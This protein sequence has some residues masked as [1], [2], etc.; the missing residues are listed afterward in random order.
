MV[1]KNLHSKSAG[2]VYIYT[3]H[4]RREASGSESLR[5]LCYKNRLASV[6]SAVG[7]DVGVAA[8]SATSKKPS[9]INIW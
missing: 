5:L 9:A 4:V 7:R 6:G 2:E 3:C 8:S 1:I